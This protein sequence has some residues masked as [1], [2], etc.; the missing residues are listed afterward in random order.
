[1]QSL[2]I[3][4]GCKVQRTLAATLPTRAGTKDQPS[5]GVDLIVEVDRDGLGDQVLVKALLPVGAPSRGL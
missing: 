3:W 2:S 5:D 1:M 4:S